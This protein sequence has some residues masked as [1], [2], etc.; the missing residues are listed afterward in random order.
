MFE[1]SHLVIGAWSFREA[2]LGTKSEEGEYWLTAPNDPRVYFAA[3]RT[4]LAWLRTGIAV[5][6]VGFVVARFGLFL[7]MLRPNG[8]HAAPHLSSTL[9]GVGFVLVGTLGI[10]GAAIQ[11][12]R[13]L[14]TLGPNERPPGYWIGLGQW[15]AWGMA[16]LSI[17]LAVYLAWGISTQ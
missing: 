15:Y 12:H 1:K 8:L 4:L 16:A 17:V 13:F 10:A 6:G 3:E 9:L 5:I 14:K 7:R 2:F 11:F